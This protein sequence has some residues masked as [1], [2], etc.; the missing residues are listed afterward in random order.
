VLYLSPDDG[1]VEKHRKLVPTGGERTVWGMG[2]G[3]T[4]RVVETPSGRIGGL[5]CYENYMPLARTRPATRSPPELKRTTIRNEGPR[6][7]LPLSNA[8]L[9]RRRPPI[10]REG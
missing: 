9:A 6:R 1:L 4:L 10:A 5:I 7:R 8:W 2:D 3:S